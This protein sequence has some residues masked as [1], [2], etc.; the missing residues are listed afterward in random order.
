MLCQESRRSISQVGRGQ[1]GL[2]VGTLPGSRERGFSIPKSLGKWAQALTLSNHHAHK[3]NLGKL[4][5]QPPQGRLSFDPCVK[6]AQEIALSC[7]FKSSNDRGC[8]ISSENISPGTH[9]PLLPVQLIRPASRD[10][11]Q[12]LGPLIAPNNVRTRFYV[13]APNVEHVP[14]TQSY[15]NSLALKAI[16][17]GRP[18]KSNDPGSLRWLCRTPQVAGSAT[19]KCGT[20]LC[21]YRM[22]DHGFAIRPR[23]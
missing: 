4:L 11:R 16:L 17:Q 3:G 5:G 21:T 10:D 19:E 2:L 9:E 7:L 14:L 12:K 15:L 22:F 1:I 6:R 18:A 13:A 20:I 8:L 23:G